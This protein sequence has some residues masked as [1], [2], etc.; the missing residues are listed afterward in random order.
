MA[1]MAD[2]GDLHHMLDVTGQY[3]PNRRMAASELKDLFACFGRRASSCPEEAARLQQG[4][5]PLERALQILPN[6]GHGGA[7]I[8]ANATQEEDA[9]LETAFV[10][11]FLAF[12]DAAVRSQGQ[13][14]LTTAINYRPRGFG[15]LLSSKQVR[16]PQLFARIL[17]ERPQAAESRETDGRLPFHCLMEASPSAQLV[18]QYLRVFPAAVS[19]E[20]NGKLPIVMA[21]SSSASTDVIQVLLSSGSAQSSLDDL[22]FFVSSFEKADDWLQNET[23]KHSQNRSE[24]PKRLHDLRS[25]LTAAKKGHVDK[26]L[27]GLRSSCGDN[28]AFGDWLAKAKS[29]LLSPSFMS[30]AIST[31][32]GQ[33]VASIESEHKRCL[34]KAAAD[35]VSAVL[36]E[37]VTLA[38]LALVVPSLPC[39]SSASEQRRQLARESLMKAMEQHSA[40]DSEQLSPETK[41]SLSDMLSSAVSSLDLFR[42]LEALEERLQAGIDSQDS[43]LLAS[44]L[45]AAQGKRV[46]QNLRDRATKVWHEVLRR[47]TAKQTLSELLEEG[48]PDSAAADAVAAAMHEV[49]MFEPKS[50]LIQRALEALLEARSRHG[51][52]E[53]PK[54]EPTI[55]LAELMQVRK[56]RAKYDDR[57]VKASLRDWRPQMGRDASRGNAALGL[58]DSLHAICAHPPSQPVI[59]S[60]AHIVSAQKV[61]T[62][63]TH[64]M[65]DKWPA[66]AR[67][68]RQL[69]LCQGR[70]ALQEALKEAIKAQQ[71]EWERDEATR[72][73][74]E[75]RRQASEL[76]CLC[77]VLSRDEEVLDPLLPRCDEAQLA[78]VLDRC[79]AWQKR[80]SCATW[81]DVTD[82]CHD[83]WTR[84]MQACAGAMA[85]DGFSDTDCE[86]ASHELQLTMAR[87]ASAV[88]DERYFMDS[89]DSFGDFMT[90][91]APVMVRAASGYAAGLI[92]HA[93]L[94]EDRFRELDTWQEAVGLIESLNGLEPYTCEKS[95]I[96]QALLQL[97][98]HLK[99]PCRAHLVR[100]VEREAQA[101]R[102]AVIAAQQQVRYSTGSALDTACATRDAARRS[103]IE[104]LQEAAQG[105]LH[106]AGCSR[107]VDLDRA[108]A[109]ATEAMKTFEAD[110]TTAHHVA[111]S[112]GQR[113][114]LE[115]DF[116][117]AGGES[118]L[119]TLGF[120][121]LH[122]DQAT[123]CVKVFEMHVLRSAEAAEAR[124]VSKAAAMLVDPLCLS[125]TFDSLANSPCRQLLIVGDAEA[126]RRRQVAQSL[127]SAKATLLRLQ[128]EL[129][130][131]H[132]ALENPPVD[133]ED[134]LKKLKKLM[135]KARRDID[136]KK[137]MLENAEEEEAEES[138]LDALRADLRAAKD[139]ARE[140][141]G[142]LAEGHVAIFKRLSCFPELLPL[143]RQADGLP[144]D[145]VS[146][147]HPERSL[148]HYENLEQLSE[149]VQR[150]AIGGHQVVL[151]EYTVTRSK[152][153][154]CYREAAFLRRLRHPSIVELEAI[155]ESEGRIYLQMSLYTNGTLDL[156]YRD[157]R[158]TQQA[159]AAVLQQLCQA[160]AHVHSNGVVHSDIKPTNVF[161]DSSGRPRLGDFDVSKDAATRRTMA[162]TIAITQGFA[163]TPGFFAPELIA[164]GPATQ[165]SDIFA[166]G[167][168]IEQVVPEQDRSLLLI[169]LIANLCAANPSERPS[170]AGATNYEYFEELFSGREEETFSCCLMCSEDC[171]YG[172]KQL[173]LS[174]GV[175]CANGLT[176]HFTCDSCLH[177][178]VHF[179]TVEELRVRGE[180]EGC[181][182]CPKAPKE[183]VTVA[184]SDFELARHLSDEAFQAYIDS[185][186]ELVEQRLAAENDV[187][188]QEAVQ[189]ELERLAQLDED[190]RRMLIVKSRIVGE[191][192][193]MKCPRQDCRQAYIDFN[194]CA[195][196]KCSRCPCNFC[197]WCLQDCGNDAHAHVRNCPHKPQ[198]TDAY[199]PRPWSTFEQHWAKRKADAVKRALADLDA[200]S[201]RAVRHDLRVQLADIEHLLRCQS[202][203]TSES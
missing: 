115:S 101:T 174:M 202:R 139:A 184:Y 129:Q 34:S 66:S 9:A 76:E 82:L 151:K 18:Q 50:E 11:L 8:F 123:M 133:V 170:A 111:V 136:M 135:G 40:L 100:P 95:E 71:S 56:D 145:L 175:M 185:R 107:E 86:A 74:A 156:W 125:L 143:V 14:V 13:P 61:L 52:C 75:L 21:L 187:R 132:E 60:S 197:G 47:E 148:Q 88:K 42:E 188:M 180:R 163:G 80:H 59:A 164:G 25:L 79:D 77:Q 203:S 146:I 160:L 85:R 199:F 177:Q 167:K 72:A 12:P 104:R 179:A 19:Q 124:R 157:H 189:R 106:A 98:E 62:S 90:A 1:R 182:L 168:T 109:Q 173:P 141:E 70:A 144:L 198:G 196:L 128:A 147:F 93:E 121:R 23:R 127:N 36:S 26:L 24:V 69:E 58:W 83:E 162:S 10:D 195:A 102:D 103:H 84:A 142:Q 55:L 64:R 117:N 122:E 22:S 51:E 150:A 191:V 4:K 158:P 68:E 44:A 172:T 192:L 30:R 27:A 119:A 6:L 166:L 155:F 138:I 165:E 5:Y 97:V 15:F 131:E 78:E 81:S 201:R 7:V 181:V 99:K 130:T 31:G 45:D 48:T 186:R 105:M 33:M 193:T 2:Y 29:L 152:L 67:L 154:T 16:F 37:A 190:Q 161:I 89:D 110:L 46:D 94:L 73:A 38:N 118:D 149:R 176:P 178:H 32:Y 112:V 137:I 134:Q 114:G 153:E 3:G 57:Q 53:R 120:E 194:G 63:F 41:N 43:Q 49:K 28:H 20:Y 113:L 171:E 140:A 39:S 92:K 108:C 35:N 200:A 116:D 183:C 54:N 126:H 159:L 169:L 96:D 17:E 87:C 65:S 91:V